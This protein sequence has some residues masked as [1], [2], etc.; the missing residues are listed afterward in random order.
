MPIECQCE[1]SGYC[2][3]RQMHVNVRHWEQC[4]SGKV[5]LVDI[6]CEQ[7][8]LSRES[9]RRASGSET[10][11]APPEQHQDRR[12]PNE[13]KP[14]PRWV[15]L[16]QRLSTPEDIGLGATVKRLASKFGG[17]RFKRLTK[18]LGMPCKCGAREAEWNRLYP[19]PNYNRSDVGL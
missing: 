1:K 2:E 11:P 6:K 3:R 7:I 14:P 8:K 16:L 9:R 10:I 13:M 17:E 19:N 15:R 18:K 12:E 5:E 4:R